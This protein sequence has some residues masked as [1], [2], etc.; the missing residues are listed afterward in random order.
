LPIHNVAAATFG[1]SGSELTFVIPHG[2]WNLEAHMPAALEVVDFRTGKVTFRKTITMS[3]PPAF[4]S[5]WSAYL[6]SGRQFAYCDYYTLHVFNLPGYTEAGRIS[7]GGPIKAP[8]SLPAVTITHAEFSSDGTKVATLLRVWRKYGG[9]GP[10]SGFVV[11]GDKLNFAVRLYD[12]RSLREVGE[13]KFREPGSVMGFAV[14]P[15][16]TRIAWSRYDEDHWTG[17]HM[18]VPRAVNNIEILD[19][20]TGKTIGVHTDDVASRLAFTPD[21]RLLSISFNP[22]LRHHDGDG[23]RIW[24]AKT[25]KLLDEVHSKPHG[26]HRALAVSNDGRVV[27][28]FV[29]RDK[30]NENFIDPKETQFRLWSPASWAVLF[31]SPVVHPLFDDEFPPL[32][33]LSPDGHSVLVWNASSTLPLV[34]Y[35]IPAWE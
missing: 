27:A 12:L 3:S 14:S 23:I 28:G 10:G 8:G 19:V 24:D 34:V 25:G 13:W 1:P 15:G 9:P 21:D 2:K 33:T 6:N 11:S 5:F 31:T 22:A 4:G 30:T 29:G 18:Y 20:A 26:V 32:F 17:Y 35:H 16:G 7:V